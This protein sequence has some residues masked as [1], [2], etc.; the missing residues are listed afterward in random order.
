MGVLQSTS[1]HQLGGLLVQRLSCPILVLSISCP[2]LG[3]TQR[4]F[5]FFSPAFL[6]CLA[7]ET[8]DSQHN[9]SFDIVVHSSSP[10]PLLASQ[11]YTGKQTGL[12]RPVNGSFSQI[13]PCWALTILHRPLSRLWMHQRPTRTC[14][15]LG[16]FLSFFPSSFFLCHGTDLLQM[17][18]GVVVDRCIV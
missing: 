5:R 10:P 4:E 18:A 14:L 6:R 3:G 8:P 12:L 15:F 16:P 1:K 2:K 11:L 17:R 7:L 9:H 13:T